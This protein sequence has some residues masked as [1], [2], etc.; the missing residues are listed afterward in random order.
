MLNNI[1]KRFI[2]FIFGCIFTRLLLVYIAKNIH[3]KYLVLLGYL[4][5]IPSFGFI[6][7]YFTKSRQTGLETFGDKIWW[8]DIRPVHSFLFLLFAFLAINKN[9]NAWIVLLIDV[10]FGLIMFLKHHYQQD[11]LKYILN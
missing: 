1:Q 2:L 4:A 8:N 3:L 7:I 11:N 5:L 10:I 9:K 6:Y